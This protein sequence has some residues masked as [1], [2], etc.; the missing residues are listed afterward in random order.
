MTHVVTCALDDCPL[1]VVKGELGL[2][3]ARSVEHQLFAAL[4]KAETFLFV[5]LRGLDYLDV[6][7]IQALLNLFRH[8]KRDGKNVALIDTV[9][10]IR[11]ELASCLVHRLVMIFPTEEHAREAVPRRKEQETG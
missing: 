3:T 7:G 6:T 11:R 5:D 1:V 4:K 2:S 10:P 9:R 8:A